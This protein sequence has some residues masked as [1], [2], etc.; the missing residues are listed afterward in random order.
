MTQPS[1]LFLFGTLRHVPLLDIVLG[2]DTGGRVT[3]ARLDGHDTILFIKEGSPVLVPTEAASVEGILLSGLSEKERERLDYYECE[4]ALAD[5]TITVE[6]PNGQVQAA[7][8]AL[9]GEWELGGRW[10]FDEW[11]AT[12]GDIA[13]EA[14]REIMAYPELVDADELD[15]RWPTVLMRASSTVRAQSEARPRAIG[16]MQDGSVD[17]SA[18]RHPYTSYF[19]FAEMDLRYASFDGE[20]GPVVKREALHA[21]DAVTVLPYDPVRDRVLLVEQFRFGTYTRGDTHPWCLE[22]IAGRID[23]GETPEDTARREATE[24]AGLTLGDLLPVANYYPS[25]GALTEYLYT[26]VALADLP[27]DAAGLG[28]LEIE[29][30]DIMAHV[31]SFDQLMGA[32][33]SGE[34]NN[35]PLILTALWLQRERPRL[36]SLQ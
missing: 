28:G 34:A 19:S 3:P 10:D 12:T 7:V 2:T 15:R 36:Q 33:T 20:P 4:Y 21:A 9:P 13:I 17:V 22:P 25:P 1:L 11:L 30:E 16:R 27:D 6:T 23:P 8:Y 31:I 18:R 35:G 24:E 14:A 26:Y 29:A 5:E 32:I